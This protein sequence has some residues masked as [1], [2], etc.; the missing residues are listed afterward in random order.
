M[1][2]IEKANT[3][4]ALANMSMRVAIRALKAAIVEMKEMRESDGVSANCIAEIND[5]IHSLRG[6][7]NSIKENLMDNRHT[8]A[9]LVDC[10]EG[11]GII[12]PQD[13]GK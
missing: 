11:G 6:A 13:G 3:A 8:C 10:L 7:K 2:S 9:T 4:C 12:V 5:H 1:N